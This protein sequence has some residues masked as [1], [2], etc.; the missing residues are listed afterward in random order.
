MTSNS[1]GR[2]GR[3]VSYAAVFRRM[4]ARLSEKDRQADQ[5][6]GR[7]FQEARL[8]VRT[9]L[10]NLDGHLHYHSMYHTEDVV[11]TAERLARLAQQKGQLSE[12]DVWLIKFAALFHDH[13]F[14]SGVYQD[15][16]AL[17]AQAAEEHLRGALSDED[18]GIIKAAIM[19]TQLREHGGYPVKVQ[20]PAT[21]HGKYLCDADVASLGRN[22]Y[23]RLNMKLY[24]ELQEKNRLQSQTGRQPLEAFLERSIHFLKAHVWHTEAAESQYGVQ[25]LVNL[26]GVQKQL[27]RLKSA[28]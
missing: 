6:Y 5:E 13:G 23:H 20:K 24:A 18:V 1:R 9:D 8:R 10:K 14:L 17:G 26:R 21:L 27:E 3:K 7:V 4:R 28:A 2:L 11:Q 19:D 25:K 16:E 15:N 12:R 22:D